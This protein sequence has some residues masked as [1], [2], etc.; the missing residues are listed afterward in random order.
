[1]REKREVRIVELRAVRTEHVS[2]VVME[3]VMEMRTVKAVREIAQ[4]E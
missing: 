2:Y 1:M 4:R 3:A